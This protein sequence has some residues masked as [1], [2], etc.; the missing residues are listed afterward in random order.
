MSLNTYVANIISWEK[1]MKEDE[2][3]QNSSNFSKLLLDSRTMNTKLLAKIDD[4]LFYMYHFLQ[5]TSRYKEDRERIIHESLIFDEQIEKIEDLRYLP[6]RQLTHLAE[7]I[8]Q[9][10]TW[11]SAVQGGILGM[12]P[13]ILASANIPITLIRSVRKAQ[14]TGLCF[15]Y[16]MI[17]PYEMIMVLKFLYITRL[18]K[19]DRYTA[20]K[21]FK[22]EIYVDPPF[23]YEGEDRLLDEKMV[24]HHGKL[25][26]EMMCIVSLRNKRV[27]QIPFISIGLS[28]LANYCRS[29]DENRFIIK[30]FQYR[31]L[32]E[33]GCFL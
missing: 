17:K 7:K 20:W 10:D 28:C 4:Y 2:S 16:E 32:L 15:G 6:I 11:L 12:S 29:N 8:C 33:K 26:L 22:K 3:F 24:I 5:G 30:Y 19:G 1:K 13:A 23:V 31:Y 25:L 27:R 9:K 14:L 21:S 18:P